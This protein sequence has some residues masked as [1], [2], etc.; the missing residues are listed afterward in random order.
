MAA[1]ATVTVPV[2]PAD[3][4]SSPSHLVTLAD[5]EWAQPRSAPP[6]PPS[7]PPG[8]VAESGAGGVG[9][10]VASTETGAKA[11]TA[12]LADPGATPVHVPLTAT[13]RA[14][15]GPPLWEGGEVETAIASAPPSP[16]TP[17]STPGELEVAASGSTPSANA[18]EPLVPA[19]APPAT[20]DVNPFAASDAATVLKPA[21]TLSPEPVPA[22]SPDPAPSGAPDGAD[23]RS[24]ERE[25]SGSHPAASCS[26]PR[27]TS[28]SPRALPPPAAV[29]EWLEDTA[30]QLTEAGLRAL[31]HPAGGAPLA[32]GGGLDTGN[33][34]DVDDEYDSRGP[35]AP[36]GV[37]PADGEVAILFRNNHFATLVARPRSNDEAGLSPPSPSLARRGR[38]SSLHPRAVSTREL[39][40]LA[41]D[42]GFG[43]AAGAGFPGGGHGAAP[44]WER[45][46]STRET[47]LCDGSF[48][49][50]ADSNLAGVG[51]ASDTAEHADLVEALRRSTLD[52]AAEAAEA[53]A[54]DA[55]MARRL[56]DDYDREEREHERERAA[57]RELRRGEEEA[58]R[59]EEEMR[60]R[61]RRE[62]R[63]A[64]EA[65]AAEAI[66]AANYFS[67]GGEAGEG[68]AA[69]GG[70][71]V[72]D[73]VTTVYRCA[74][75]GEESWPAPAVRGRVAERAP[76]CGLGG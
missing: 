73:D 76:Q 20:P 49:P 38:G 59:R 51:G 52:P 45:L 16:L 22:P 61:E 3:G 34:D 56:Q 69:T 55:A 13:E 46:E 58:A 15:T 63:R 74:R 30:G 1:G 19:M 29:R 2:G 7:P 42:V 11:A 33:E 60:R 27:L 50:L 28:P 43:S 23:R 39:Y 75:L 62:R 35:G 68:G 9:G 57:R 26:P 32:D 44:V 41:T 31:R 71:G 37:G 40:T 64:E 24:R 54:A 18:P 14:A 8:P 53:A 6:M 72:R 5:L 48:R 67:G 47:V 36:G 65:A 10:G 12:G 66:R 21:P 17:L 70:E 4:P 25:R